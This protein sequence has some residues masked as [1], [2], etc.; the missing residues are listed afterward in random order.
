M[1]HQAIFHT[2]NCVCNMDAINGLGELGCIAEEKRSG[3]R[4]GVHCALNYRR[5]AEFYHSCRVA[6]EAAAAGFVT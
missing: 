2:S 4:S 6:P 1:K 5:S 3:V